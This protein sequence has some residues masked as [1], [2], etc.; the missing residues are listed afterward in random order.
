M[1][2]A[3]SF[4]RLRQRYLDDTRPGGP[5]GAPALARALEFIGWHAV[6]EPSPEELA[7]H[8][9]LLLDACVHEHHD[10]MLLTD[11]VAMALRDTGPLLDGGLPP[12]QAYLPAAEELLHRYVSDDG[13]SRATPLAFL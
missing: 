9:V 11:G 6:R 4:T 2:H 3:L 13:A 7:Q 1:S 5:G 10:V 8:L 12:V